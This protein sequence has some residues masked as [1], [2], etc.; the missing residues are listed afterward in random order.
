[1]SVRMLLKNIKALKEDPERET[2]DKKELGL[3]YRVELQKKL[4]A[5]FS[6]VFLGI[7]G[8]LFSLGHHRSGKSVSYG[9]SM[10]VVFI[11][12][13]LFNVGIVLAS[14]GTVGPMVGVWTPNLALGS[15]TGY[16]YYKK[17]RWG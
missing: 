14:K 3:Q 9:L 12:I 17:L 16:M 11:Y 8:V 15:L 10:G 2:P 5:P 13:M 4:A 6:S 7:L 1:M